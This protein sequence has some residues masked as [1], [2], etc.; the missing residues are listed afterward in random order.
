MFDIHHQ[1]TCARYHERGELMNEGGVCTWGG[2]NS[3]WTILIFFLRV[4]TKVLYV[5]HGKCGEMSEM[6]HGWKK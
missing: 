2:N 6:S 3:G 4:G 5:R 1:G